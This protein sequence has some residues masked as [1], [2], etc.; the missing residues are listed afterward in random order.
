MVSQWL[1]SRWRR[2]ELLHFFSFSVIGHVVGSTA[3]IQPLLCQFLFR[4]HGSHGLAV[5]NHLDFGAVPKFPFSGPR[6]LI[7]NQVKGRGGSSAGKGGVRTPRD[8]EA[9]GSSSESVL[10]SPEPHGDILG[11]PILDP[12]YRSSE[13][14]PSVPAGLQP[15]P[16][17]WEWLVIREDA[18]A[19]VAWTPNFRE[20]RDL[21][22]QRNEMLAVPLVFDFQCSRAVEWADWIDSEG[23]NMYRDT[24]ALR[25][26]VRRW[27]PSTHTFFFAHGEM[28]VTLEDV[29]NHWLLPIL[30]DQ[31]P[32]DLILS[33]EELEIESALADYI[34]RKNIALGTQAARFKAWMEHF[35][36]ETKP[37]IRRAAFVAYWLSKCVFGEHPAYSIKPL[38]FPLAVKIA[39]GVCFPLAPLLL[40]Q[41]YTQLDLL[42]AEELAGASCHIV[43]TAF[44]SSIVHTFLWEHALEYIKKGRK[45][46]EGRNKFASMPDGIVANVGDFQGDVP[47][48]YRWVGMMSGFSNI[49]AQD[50]SI[51]AG[52]TA[53]L[54]YL[55]ATNAGW[56]PV[57]SSDGLRFTVYSAHRVRKQFGFD[58][59]VPAVM[60]VAAGEIPTLNPFLRDRAFAYW[61]SA[62]ARVIIPSGDRVGVYTTGMSNYWRGLMAAMV[63]FRNSGRGDI[64]HLLESYTSPLP[65]PRF[66]HPPLWLRDHPHVAASGKAPSSR[67]KRNVPTG[68]SAAKRK[69]PERS[70]K[71][72]TPSKDSPARA[73]KRQKASAMKGSKET[74]VLE[75]AAAAS[76]PLT[77]EDVPQGVSAPISKRTVKKTRAGKKTFVPPA[78]PGAPSSIAARV[79]ARKSSRGVVYSEKRSKQRADTSSRVPIE[80]PDDLDSS[81]SSSDPSGAVEEEVERESVG[82]GVAE[83]VSGAG[84][85]AADISSADIGS[86]DT[87]AFLSASSGE[88]DARAEVDTED[89]EV[90]MDELEAAEA[91]SESTP[92]ASAMVVLHKLALLGAAVAWI[93]PCSIQVLPLANMPEGLEGGSIVSTDS[94]RTGSATVRVS[95]PPSPLPESGGI[96]STPIIITAAV[97]AATIIQESETATAA[98]GEVPGSEEGPTHISEIPEGIAR[99]EHIEVA[100]SEDPVQAEVIP[101]NMADAHDSYDEV[102]AEAEGDVAGAQAADTGATAS[103]AA[104]GSPTQT[105]GSGNEVVAEEEII[106]QSAAVESAIRGHPELVPAARPVL[107]RT[108]VLA[109]MDAFFRE[110]DR[111]S[112]SSRHAEHFW[113]FDDRKADF[114]IF[115]VP[116]GGIRFLR[117]LWDKY[118]RC[119]LYFRRGVHVGS[120][121]LTLLCCV[122]AHM[123]YTRLEDI[124]E[125]MVS[126]V[127]GVLAE[128]R[129]A[130]ARVAAL[131]DA[132][133]IVAP[134]P[135]D[136]AAAR[137]ASAE[138]SGGSALH[139]LL[140]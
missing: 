64:S 135:W 102:L 31:G 17:D 25:Q 72:E 6:W 62:A 117:A 30:G 106:H 76:P 140:A 101:G 39:A 124:T 68:A 111:T 23:S 14:F 11:R 20:I 15:P 12:W 5:F 90:S 138:S 19:D 46:Y 100:A 115:R 77:G 92:V 55:S 1:L 3:D 120:S 2:W 38:Y 54:T 8:P 127:G 91:S 93:P 82:A 119:S 86:V 48:V 103:V 75:A 105:A 59:E 70:S 35:N 47:A 41:I 69:Q 24:E 56:L 131:R 9:D 122:L 125:L 118:G 74:L 29:E 98:V 27:C 109:D 66:P 84:D 63:E 40:G 116:Q 58:Q 81:S 16:A 104:H 21:Q 126:S 79:A 121:L 42:H 128:L 107:P 78:F 85:F 97:S 7:R 32:A 4:L 73:S 13:R 43:S 83:T 133:N 87:D 67:G 33:P 65:H 123:E 49:E 44:N 10:G 99:I 51:V 37:S 113:T 18:G 88:K 28:T 61:S 53:S 22:I 110:F 89:D 137:G 108:S 139:D 45:P 80:I 114:E 134:N 60:G 136:L 71:G 57:L 50:Y 36:R 130:E 112:F 95:T 96:A 132:L 94:E 129:E 52:D 34:G 26:L